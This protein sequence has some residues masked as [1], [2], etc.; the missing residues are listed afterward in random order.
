MKNVKIVWEDKSEPEP[1]TIA[2]IE[3]G[4]C[5]AYNGDLYRK[6]YPIIIENTGVRNAMLM[7]NAGLCN[8]MLQPIKRV[9]S[10]TI[11]VKP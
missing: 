9:Q 6:I 8:F 7:G 4:A 2:D 5:F 1:I 11:T 10:V 3:V